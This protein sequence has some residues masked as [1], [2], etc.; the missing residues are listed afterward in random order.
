MEGWSLH[1]PPRRSTSQH[2]SKM[3][4]G[5]AI[6]AVALAVLPLL[7]QQNGIYAPSAD[8]SGQ[9]VKT[10]DGVEVRLGKR[11]TL[12]I[13]ESVLDSQNNENT[14]F[15]AWVGVP[16]DIGHSNV[17]IIDGAAYRQGG[18]ASDKGLFS[19]GFP[20]SGADKARQI[21]AYLKAPVRLRQDPGHPLRVSF[22]PL[23]AVFWVGE[24][25][26]LKMRI[27]NVSTQQ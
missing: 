9:I 15:Y 1:R 19:L 7:A 17:L 26:N 5:I 27:T 11:M 16:S 6:L 23:K 22:V 2:T 25:V 20:V 10:Q 8:K 3:R 4:S 21:A 14:T 24:P 18:S 13:G 12:P